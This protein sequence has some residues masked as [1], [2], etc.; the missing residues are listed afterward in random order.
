M[1]RPRN[2]RQRRALPDPRRDLRRPGMADDHGEE[3]SENASSVHGKGGDEVEENEHDIHHRQF[4]QERSRRVGEIR[5]LPPVEAQADRDEEPRR[6]D[7]VHERPGE[8]DDQFLM[9]LVRHALHA[10]DPSDGQ[11]GDV[12]RLDAEGLRGDGVAELV[13]EDARKEQEDEAD[14]LH[15]GLFP[16]GQVIADP[17][18]GEQQEE[19]QMDPDFDAGDGGDTDGPAHGNRG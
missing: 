12:R 10:G 1:K 13:Q 3:R 6:D 15:G 17:D 14:P 9:G 8:R 2:R 7:H 5:G 16:S 19:G 18:E 4:R 11:Q